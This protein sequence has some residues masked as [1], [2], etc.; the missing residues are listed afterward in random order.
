MDYLRMKKPLCYFCNKPT[1]LDEY[2]RYVCRKCPTLTK[3]P[4][5]WGEVWIHPFVV[6]Q[7]WI[8]DET[9]YLGFDDLDLTIAFRNNDV[10]I[11]YYNDKDTYDEPVKIDIPN[12]NDLLKLPAETLKAKIMTWRTF[13]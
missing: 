11:Y 10:R 1:K 7:T 5:R 13:Q 3:I 12:A 8:E 9:T 4:D 2:D 6:V